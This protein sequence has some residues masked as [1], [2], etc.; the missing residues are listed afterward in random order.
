MTGIVCSRNC[1]KSY[2]DAIR[3]MKDDPLFREKTG[4]EN[5]KRAMSF[6]LKETGNVMRQVY[7]AAA[8]RQTEIQGW[9]NECGCVD[10]GR[11]GSL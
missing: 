10:H 7:Q 9:R 5:R 4:R 3:R 6:S 8:T 11:D 2:M 1:T